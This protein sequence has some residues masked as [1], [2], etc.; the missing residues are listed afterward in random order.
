MPSY[1]QTTEPPLANSVIRAESFETPRDGHRPV[2]RRSEAGAPTLLPLE[3]S[4]VWA[5]SEFSWNT[6][7]TLAGIGAGNSGASAQV[8]L[9]IRCGASPPTLCKLDQKAFLS[10]FRK[11]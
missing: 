2:G 5:C 8:R 3:A 11:P 1:S 10:R 9:F 6:A 4:L 7:F